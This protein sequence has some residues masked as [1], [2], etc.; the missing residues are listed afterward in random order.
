MMDLEPLKLTTSD[1]KLKPGSPSVSM[2]NSM[3]AKQSIIVEEGESNGIKEE[4]L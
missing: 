1:S 3:E 2:D 4:H